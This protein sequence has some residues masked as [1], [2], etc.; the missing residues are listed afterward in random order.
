[1]T[2]GPTFK[3]ETPPNPLLIVPQRHAGEG[4]S[5]V[6][7]LTRGGGWFNRPGSIRSAARRPEPLI[8]R[9]P[10]IGFRVARTLE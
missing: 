6:Q 10:T 8:L 2:G 7:S 3:A 9:L 1:M 4:T 5:S